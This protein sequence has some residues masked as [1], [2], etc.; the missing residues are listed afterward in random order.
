MNHHSKISVAWGIGGNDKV[1]QINSIHCNKNDSG[2][3]RSRPK[4]RQLS[5]RTG[6]QKTPPQEQIVS[7]GRLGSNQQNVSKSCPEL[8]KISPKADIQTDKPQYDRPCEYACV[9]VTLQIWKVGEDSKKKRR[10][11]RR[12]K[13]KTTIKNK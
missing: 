9:C 6:Y 12:T 10:T 11:K 5:F 2:Q 3:Q 1:P 7:R 13:K 4:H 8:K